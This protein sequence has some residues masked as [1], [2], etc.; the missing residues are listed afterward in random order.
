MYVPAPFVED[1]PDVLHAFIREHPFATL[2]TAD[3][4]GV[5]LVSHLPLLLPHDPPG[6][7]NTPGGPAVLIGHLAKANAQVEH[8]SARRPVLAVFH[9][10]H[11]YV[12]PRW[13]QTSPAVPTWNYSAVHVYGTARRVD[14][15]AELRDLLDRTV[16]A[17]EPTH[18][19]WTTDGLPDP[20]LRSMT[21]GICGFAFAIDRIEGKFKL[22]QNRPAADRAG[23]IARL[24]EG[25]SE[26]RAVAHAMRP[27]P[28]A[29]A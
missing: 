25:T 15:P 10:P 27:W 28:D 13:Y 19:G 29:R 11:A 22:S 2:V 1:R 6:L 12:S 5:P 14:D 26:E 4:A 24:A 16:R 20:Y 7:Q 9:G 17:F 3:A 21:A 8:L 18:G 23:V